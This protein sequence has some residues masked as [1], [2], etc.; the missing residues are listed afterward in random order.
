MFHVE[1]MLPDEFQSIFDVPRGTFDRLLAYEALLREWQS[2]MNLVG[3]GTLDDVWGRHF[4]DSAQLSR[5]VPAGKSRVDIGAGAGF[6]GLVQAAMGWGQFT[7]VDSVQKKCRFLLA[8]V[9]ALE[10]SSTVSIVC[11][12]IEALPTIGAEVATARAAAPLAT[13]FDWSIRHVRAGGLYVFPKGRNWAEEVEIAERRFAF[14][15]DLVDSITDA[16]ARIIV[17]RTLKRR[18]S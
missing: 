6:P 17:A 1:H 12:R 2:V 3:P 11:A 10:L 5:I 14:D 18:S 7:L 4:A 16:D 15:H 9:D 8:V 13:L